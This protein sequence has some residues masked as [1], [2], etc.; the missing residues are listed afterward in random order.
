MTNIHHTTKEGDTLAKLAQHHQVLGSWRAIYDHY[1]NR[2]F[3]KKF[4][5]LTNMMQLPPVN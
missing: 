3:Q 4:P 2:A 1:E 5:N